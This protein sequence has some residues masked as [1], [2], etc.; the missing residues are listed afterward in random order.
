MGL[1]HYK[2][3]LLFVGQNRKFNSFLPVPSFLGVICDH[4]SYSSSGTFVSEDF[5]G[6]FKI[7][8]IIKVDSNDILPRLSVFIS[9]FG[10]FESIL[11]LFCFTVL[12]ENC[13]RLNFLHQ[14]SGLLEHFKVQVKSGSFFK[15]LGFFI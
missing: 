12:D 2:G 8:E 7:I 13:R 5:F 11:R 3:F 4:H 9:F 15:G 1:S 10:F 6:L 14:R